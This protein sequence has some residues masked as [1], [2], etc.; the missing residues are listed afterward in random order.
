VSSE[1]APPTE[2]CRMHLVLVRSTATDDV[3]MAETSSPESQAEES[4]D[5]WANVQRGVGERG[6]DCGCRVWSGEGTCNALAEAVSGDAAEKGL[7]I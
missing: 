3:M 2:A 6:T 4:A 7:E 1:G 5:V